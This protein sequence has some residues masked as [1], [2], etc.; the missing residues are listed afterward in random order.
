MSNAFPQGMW[1]GVFRL[2]VSVLVALGTVTY[3]YENT[4][5]ALLHDLILHHL[6]P[7]SVY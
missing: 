6:T 5:Q 3:K 7:D 1:G 2:T 4:S